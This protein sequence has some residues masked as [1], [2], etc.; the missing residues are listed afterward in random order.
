MDENYD[1]T[2]LRPRMGVDII[3]NFSSN[4]QR[5]QFEDRLELYFTDLTLNEKFAITRPV[6]AIAGDKDDYEL[7][8]ARAPYIRPKASREHAITEFLPG[9]PPPALAEITWV[10]RLDHY[11]M[12]S[13]L[14]EVAFG[15]GSSSDIAK[16][17][18]NAWLPKTF[19]G[20]TY[21]RQW[22]II[23]WIEEERARY[24]L[25]SVNIMCQ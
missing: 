23:L 16:R 15:K 19:V 1:G 14:K 5:G 24:V 12:P 4:N 25:H 9:V 20:K 2:T 11:D 13:G 7:L 17:V 10:V 6:R 22:S 8:R 21:G 18:R 3:L